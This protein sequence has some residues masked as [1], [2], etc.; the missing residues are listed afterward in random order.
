MRE[1]GEEPPVAVED[2]CSDGDAKLDVL[3]VRPVHLAPPTV[4]AA[5]SAEPFLPLESRE[6]A[7]IRIGDQRHVPAAATIP[8][9]GSAARDVLLPAKAEPAV[10]AAAGLDVDARSIVEH[11][12]ASLEQPR[13]TLL[14]THSRR[15]IDTHACDLARQ[16]GCVLTFAPRIPPRLLRQLVRLDD[17]SVAIAETYRRLGR[18]ADRMGITRPSYERVRVLIHRLRAAARQRAVVRSSSR[19]AVRVRAIELFVDHGVRIGVRRLE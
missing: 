5:W 8:A 14:R 16:S 17:P 18:A 2:L 10:A 6:I 3:A 13:N 4:A 15:G 1:I 19:L 11:G 7:Q 9:V 12:G